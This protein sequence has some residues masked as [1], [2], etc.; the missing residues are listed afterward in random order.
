MIT[1]NFKVTF[2]TEYGLKGK[3]LSQD[4]GID[5]IILNWIIGKYG[6]CVLDSFGWG[7]KPVAGSCEYGVKHPGSRKGGV[8]LTSWAYN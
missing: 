5:G 1:E 3:D 4:L 2:R 7:C 6:V 8:F